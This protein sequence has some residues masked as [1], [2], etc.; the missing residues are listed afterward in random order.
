LSAKGRVIR[1]SRLPKIK[2][3]KFPGLP[4]VSEDQVIFPECTILQNTETEILA[5]AIILCCAREGHYIPVL[6]RRLRKRSLEQYP[7]IGELDPNRLHDAFQQ[8]LAFGYL[9]VVRVKGSPYII[10]SRK[11]ARIVLEQSNLQ[12]VGCR[13]Q[14]VPLANPSQWKRILA[15][16]L[17][18]IV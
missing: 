13:Q 18:L 4:A 9:H 17:R 6:E 3:A 14:A 11:L 5:G 2:Q 12:I 10:P 7:Q 16:L 8:M 15:A 1:L